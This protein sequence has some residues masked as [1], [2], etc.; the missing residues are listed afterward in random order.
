MTR[1][2]GSASAG[3]WSAKSSLAPPNPCTSRTGAPCPDDSTTRPTPS[4]IATRMRL[5]P[6]EGPPRLPV[7]YGHVAPRGRSRALPRRLGPRPP[8]GGERGPAGVA[9]QQDRLRRHGPPE[10]Q[11]A[12]DARLPP[13]GDR[14]DGV[15][16]CPRVLAVAAGP[17]RVRRA[18]P[19]PPPRLPLLRRALRREPA[20]PHPP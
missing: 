3:T 4:S 9:R 13:G 2:A 1:V 12:G 5:R 14:P 11:P 6:S 8:P 16:P 15:Q 18:R 19:P 7:I 17:R 10:P 20:P